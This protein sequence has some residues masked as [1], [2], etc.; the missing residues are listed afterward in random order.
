VRAGVELAYGVSVMT[1]II[2]LLCSVLGLSLAGQAWAD[3]DDAPA[4]APAAVETAQPALSIEQEQAVGITVLHPLPASAGE[5]IEGYGEVLDAAALVSDAGRLASTRAAPA[6]PAPKRNVWRGSIAARPM[7]RS[8]PLR[9]P[10]LRRSRHRRR[11]RSPARP[12]HCNGDR[13]PSSP[14]RS[15]QP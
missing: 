14:T 5:R 3:D 15:V 11:R 4:P 13:W 12:S 8:D 9:A 7:P 10:R 6:P 2:P 1:R